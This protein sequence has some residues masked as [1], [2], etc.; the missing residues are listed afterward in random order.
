MSRALT[1]AELNAMFAAVDNA[2]AARQETTCIECGTPIPAGRT[3]CSWLCRS[4]DDRH[5]AYDYDDAEG[6]L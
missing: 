1:V 2:A 6:D 4:M 5:D 3:W